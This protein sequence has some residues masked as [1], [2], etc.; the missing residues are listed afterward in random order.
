MK[1]KKK[2]VFTSLV[3]GDFGMITSNYL[4][5]KLKCFLY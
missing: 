3:V 4:N 1:V 2:D 5:I